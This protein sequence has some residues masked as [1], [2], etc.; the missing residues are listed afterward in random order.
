MLPKQVQMTL[1]VEANQ[2]ILLVESSTKGRSCNVGRLCLATPHWQHN[3]DGQRGT[4]VCVC[5][6]TYAEATS[7]SGPARPIVCLLASGQ[8]D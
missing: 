7:L 5:F 4:P 1:P 6:T 8:L 2:V 3:V